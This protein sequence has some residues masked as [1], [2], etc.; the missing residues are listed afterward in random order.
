MKP[1][2]TRQKTVNSAI[3]SA[4]EDMQAKIVLIHFEN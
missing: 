3:E 1:I 2:D 4:P